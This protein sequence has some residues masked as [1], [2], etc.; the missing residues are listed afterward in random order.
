VLTQADSVRLQGLRRARNQRVLV[1]A[2]AA[3]TLIT[4]SAYVYGVDLR[5]FKFS[6]LGSPFLTLIAIAPPV[7]PYLISFV[8][9]RRVVTGDDRRAALFIALLTIGCALNVCLLTGV[10]GIV[11]WGFILEY[12][13]FQS[14][15]Y[16]WGAELLLNVV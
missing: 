15:A 12:V 9:S 6:D 2:H 1:G 5:G 3:L 16:V 13:I 4:A 11:G 7:I 14:F 10:F 8:Y